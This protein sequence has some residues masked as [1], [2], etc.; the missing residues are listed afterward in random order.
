[1][2]KVTMTDRERDIA[3][4]I[5]GVCAQI[6]PDVDKINDLKDE[7]VLRND[8]LSTSKLGIMAQIAEM[9]SVGKWL[10][11]EITHATAYAAKMGNTNPDDDRSAKSLATFLSEMNAVAHPRVR[12]RFKELLGAVEEAWAA[13]EQARA[14]D[15]DVETPVR[16]WAKRKYHAILQTMRAV[17]NGD[18]D[19]SDAADVVAWAKTNDPDFDAEHVAKR[20]KTIAEALQSV[21]VDF[22]NEDVGVAQRY[23][24]AITAEDL[25]ES[26]KV[27]NAA[28]AKAEREYR[29]ANTPKPAPTPTPVPASQAAP[30]AVQ[31]PAPTPTPIA[32]APAPTPIATAPAAEQAPS[33]Q[34]IDAGAPAEGVFDPLASV[35]NDLDMIEQL[36]A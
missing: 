32:A 26:L 33:S 25:L 6:V 28:K 10:P 2:A 13:E 11:G 8:T 27:K 12:D 7:T 24:A 17:K 18:A 36:A 5:R 34:P 19:I 22:A 29:L 16:K 31:A 35:M 23:V 14:L 4:Q 30:Q 9:S 20:L 3:E 1:M 21:F 15:K